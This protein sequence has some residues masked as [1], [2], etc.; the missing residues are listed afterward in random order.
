MVLRV[1]FFLNF[2][3]LS[4]GFADFFL[5]EFQKGESG[6]WFR[7]CMLFGEGGA[8]VQI[9]YGPRCLKLKGT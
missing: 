7:I 2:G 9:F 3:N 4:K 6:G 5:G 1:Y 8:V